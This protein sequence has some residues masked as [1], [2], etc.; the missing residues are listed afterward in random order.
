[1][2]WAVSTAVTM[3]PRPGDTPVSLSAVDQLVWQAAE[4]VAQPF[5]CRYH[6]WASATAVLQPMCKPR[7]CVDWARAS[8]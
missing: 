1:M 7:S 3:R 8:Q 6:L 2:A 4:Q 5:D